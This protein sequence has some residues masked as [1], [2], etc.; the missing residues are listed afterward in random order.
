MHR[1]FNRFSASLQA[2]FIAAGTIFFSTQAQAQTQ[3]DA[4]SVQQ[5]IS[6]LWGT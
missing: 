3:T 1:S 5:I 6:S 4:G 2:V